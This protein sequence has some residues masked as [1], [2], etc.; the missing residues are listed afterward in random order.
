MIY[1]T[2]SHQTILLQIDF[3]GFLRAKTNLTI[4]P[5]N[6][7]LK[8]IYLNAKN[9]KILS[10][11]I[12]DSQLPF[13]LSQPSPAFPQANTTSNPDSSQPSLH[14]QIHQFP[15]LKRALFVSQ[16]ESEEGELRIGGIS[17]FIK[18]KPTSSTEASDKKE[19]FESF[20]LEIEYEIVQGE[21]GEN[22]E[23]VWWRGCGR[24]VNEDQDSEV[25]YY[26][27]FGLITFVTVSSEEAL[28]S[29]VL[30]TLFLMDSFASA[31]QL[32][33]DKSDLP[34]LR[35][36]LTFSRHSPHSI[37]LDL[38]SPAL[39]HSSPATLGRSSSSLLP[40]SSHPYPPLPPVL[41]QTKNK[42]T[43]PKVSLPQ[44]RARRK[45]R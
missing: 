8:T 12:N 13:S 14:S 9:L 39:T 3:N 44:S 31:F 42:T 6:K 40:H 38:G 18:L 25:S 7:N 20:E 19:E 2:V 34:S 45:R 23:G 37:P 4:S 35:F 16:N 5:Q 24:Q 41:T 11:S 32:I 10:C 26:I 36:H 1:F 29:R 28:I 43:N 17:N 22:G 33:G 27:Q 15:I 21:F 30:F